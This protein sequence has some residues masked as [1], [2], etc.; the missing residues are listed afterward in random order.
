[1]VGRSIS[2]YGELIHFS[3]GPFT[4]PAGTT[5]TV[6]NENAIPLAF[7]MKTTAQRGV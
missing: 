2:N 6:T 1:M 3:L 4:Q 7:K 5:L